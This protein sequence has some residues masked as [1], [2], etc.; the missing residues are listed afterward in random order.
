MKLLSD[1]IHKVRRLKA[2]DME[3]KINNELDDLEMKNARFKVNIVKQEEF[4]I[5][6]QDSVE[7]LI[8]T[9]IG[10]DFKSLTKVVSGG[11]M[12]RIMLAIKNV[13]SNV[14]I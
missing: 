12:S 7:F 9:N 4:N 11:E 1:Q 5:Y 13:L 10:E 14:V 8:C 2:K 6:G 3:E